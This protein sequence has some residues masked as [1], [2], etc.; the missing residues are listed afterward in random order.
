M[1]L[2]DIGCGVGLIHRHIAP[3]FGDV[4]G[5]D[6]AGDALE[7]A[8]S[9]NPSVRYQTYDGV[10][11]PFEENA[12]DTAVAT[13]VMHHVPPQQWLVFV[14]EAIRVLRPGGVFMV[15]EH[16]PW[17]PLTRLAVARCAFDF[18]AV[19]LNPPRLTALLRGGGLADVSRE[20][21]FFTPF[22]NAPAQWAEQRLRWCPAGAQYVAFGRRPNAA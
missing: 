6:V 20:F 8:Q 9:V 21:M 3:D 2:L 11:L 10:R 7:V 14:A 15:F 16:N 17:N 12:F 19:L 18:D 4:V 13:C 22:S 1:R 5:V